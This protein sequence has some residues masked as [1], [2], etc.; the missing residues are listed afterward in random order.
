[1]QY[2]RQQAETRRLSRE[3][4]ALFMAGVLCVTLAVSAVMLTLAATIGNGLFFIRIPDIAWLEEHPA[5]VISTVLLILGVMGTAVLLKRME[6]RDGGGA[7]A[8]SLGGERIN[9]DSREPLYRRLHNV[10]EEI[11]I[12]AGMPLPEVYVL[13][14]EAGI[15]AFAAG[16]TPADAAI[17]VTRGALE[18]L[19]RDEL[20]G[21]IA[22]EFS[23][24]V[25]DDI[26]LNM[27]LI[28]WLYGLM[29]L[30]VVGR[31][32][33]SFSPSDERGRR[34]G[35]FPVM[36]AAALVVALGYMGWLFGRLIQAAV[37]RRREALADASAVQ[38]TRNPDGLRGALLKIAASEN[39]A[40]LQQ[41][42]TDT[43]AH[44]L[45]FPASTSWF[46]THPPLP[47][48]IRALGGSF[49]AADIERVRRQLHQAGPVN[50]PEAR[51]TMQPLPTVSGNLALS[52][53]DAGAAASPLRWG[54]RMRISMPG[55]IREAA[56]QS[57][58]ATAVLFALALAADNPLRS[59]QLQIIQQQ[60]G[61][62]LA[63]RVAV[64]TNLVDRLQ[65]VQRQPAAQLLMPPL[66][67]LPNDTR[68]RLSSCLNRVLALTGPVTVTQY[69]LRKLVQGQ[70]HEVVA[71]KAQPYLNLMQASVSISSLLLVVAQEGHAQPDIASRAYE[72]GMQHLGLRSYAPFKPAAAWPAL[73]DSALAQLNRLHPAG[74]QLLV[75]A[76]LKAVSHD[77]Q[78]MLQELE[79]LR[80]ICACLQCPPP[81]L[82]DLELQ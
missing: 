46:A 72:Q 8:R 7:V 11:A 18:L 64:M 15:N 74:K 81:L 41:V 67:Q 17:T 60:L 43:V 3:L 12:A 51:A 30:S 13:P 61:G 31:G 73:L 27:S 82:P 26:R 40:R 78:I 28:A 48:R 55:E 32:M 56:A 65:P 20:Q 66:R 44:L 2:F 54:E 76:L 22:H 80:V 4:V 71:T 69:A 19:T 23:H 59:Q 79:L 29:A 47:E 77:G 35:F 24:I 21:V 37:A 62:P 16:L 68:L 38:F 63:Q 33:F 58:A 14:R 25:N 9:A 53:A 75:E 39:G 1:M 50:E 45:F 70:L 10:I 6:L 52:L 34:G 57:E 5:N 42:N 49:H 36:I